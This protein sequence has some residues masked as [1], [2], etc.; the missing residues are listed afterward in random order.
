MATW[1]QQGFST[2]T[3]LAD[4]LVQTFGLPFREAHHITGR[5]VQMA[6]VQGC[7]LSDLTLESLQK[8]HP[9]ITAEV[10]TVLSAKA[11]L[12]R[13]TSF[14]GASPMRVAEALSDAE[15]RWSL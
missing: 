6:E 4:Y 11:S 3:D 1:A 8:A 9:P 2:A 12:H 10:Y 5:I 15:A 14:G 7:D 13:R